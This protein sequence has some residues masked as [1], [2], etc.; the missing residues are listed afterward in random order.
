[1][2]SIAKALE[3]L[4]WVSQLG[5][6]LIMPLLLCMGLCYW[7]TTQHGVGY[8]VYLPAFVLGIGAGGASF[9]NFWKLTQRRAR[10]NEKERKTNKTISFN[11]HD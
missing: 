9:W 2:K 5:L 4:V 3:D 10:Q 1:M 11:R 8:W 6:S 7:L